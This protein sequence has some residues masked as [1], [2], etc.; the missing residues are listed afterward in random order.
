MK[1]ILFKCPTTGYTVQYLVAEKT[2][3]TEPVVVDDCPLCASVH[4]VHAKPASGN[5]GIFTTD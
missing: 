3:E 5:P 1:P 2:D 4:I